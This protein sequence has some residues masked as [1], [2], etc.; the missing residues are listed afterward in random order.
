MSHHL[1]S[2]IPT[3]R[4]PRPPSIIYSYQCYDEHSLSIFILFFVSFLYSFPSLFFPVGLN[5]AVHTSGKHSPM[6]PYSSSHLYLLFWDRVCGTLNSS[7]S[8]N[9]LP[10]LRDRWTVL[11]TAWLD[12]PF[13]VTS[14]LICCL[15]CLLSA[16]CTA[17]NGA[18]GLLS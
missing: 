9:N 5:W 7:C 11:P 8:P 15:S 18:L 12:K 14:L 17:G 16:R 1:F 4:H 10:S 2:Q 13:S 6:E 3:S